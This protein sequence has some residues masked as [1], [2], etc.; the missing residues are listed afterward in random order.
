[1]G[2]R[3]HIAQEMQ[4]ELALIHAANSDVNRRCAACTSSLH[5]TVVP[6]RR[7]ITLLPLEIMFVQLCRGLG[8]A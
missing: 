7:R 4:E 3:E 8:R 2:L 1:M 6:G 5:C